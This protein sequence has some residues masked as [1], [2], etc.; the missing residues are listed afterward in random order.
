MKKTLAALSGIA[1]AASLA[2]TAIGQDDRALKAAVDARQ[3]LMDLYAFNLGLLGG[4]AKG[5]I[6]YDADAASKA[7]GNLAALSRLDGSRMWPPGSDNG[8][9]GDETAALAAIRA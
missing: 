9:L 1:L 2:T 7:A 5:D 3:G 8:A 4:M 6:A